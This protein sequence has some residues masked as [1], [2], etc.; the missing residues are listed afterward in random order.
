MSDHILGTLTLFA[1]ITSSV[2]IIHMMKIYNLPLKTV[3]CVNGYVI[4]SLTEKIKK[5]CLFVW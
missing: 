5:K 2:H 3:S 1:V 4:E